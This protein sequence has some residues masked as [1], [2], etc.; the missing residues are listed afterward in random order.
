MRPENSWK[1]SAGHFVRWMHQK[2]VHLRSVGTLEFGLLDPAELNLRNESIILF[3][4]LAQLVV[5]DREDF[6]RPVGRAGSHD[7]PTVLDPRRRRRWF[8]AHQ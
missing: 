8:G 6:E 3:G 5:P 2:A 1:F 4:Q 7:N